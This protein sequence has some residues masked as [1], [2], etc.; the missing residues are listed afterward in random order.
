MPTDNSELKAAL[1]ATKG[2]EP[3]YVQM[4]AKE[5]T[6][7]GCGKLKPTTPD[8]RKLAALETQGLRLPSANEGEEI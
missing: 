5:A 3:A 1:A 6:R 4:V 2:A 7:L 8:A